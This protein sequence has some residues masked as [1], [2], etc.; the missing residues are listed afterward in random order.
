MYICISLTYLYVFTSLLPT[1]TYYY[2]LNDIIYRNIFFDSYHYFS[3]TRPWLLPH[4]S[5]ER[6]RCIYK[7]AMSSNII[8]EYI[9][10]V[11]RVHNGCDVIFS[12]LFW[13]ISVIFLQIAIYH[14]ILLT[15]ACIFLGL[16]LPEMSQNRSAVYS[17]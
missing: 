6:G 8:Y 12:I 3:L 16:T 14:N 17:F 13:T 1:L 15:I 5:V 4:W 9:S 10:Y 7:S 2:L 11:S